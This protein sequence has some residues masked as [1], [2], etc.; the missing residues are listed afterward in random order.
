MSDKKGPPPGGKRAKKA[1]RKRS[2]GPRQQ[3]ERPD[4]MTDR[5]QEERPDKSKGKKG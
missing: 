5:Q 2:I 3:V 4:P 1:L